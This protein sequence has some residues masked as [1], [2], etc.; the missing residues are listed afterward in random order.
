MDYDN[1]SAQI[2]IRR[3]EFLCP[4]L[5]AALSFFKKEKTMWGRGVGPGGCRAF[6][7]KARAFFFIRQ[8]SLT[9][10]L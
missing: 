1:A 7:T 9:A 6:Q 10:H 2:T 8:G 5:A 3:N 4:L